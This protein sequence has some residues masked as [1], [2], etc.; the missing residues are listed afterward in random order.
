MKCASYGHFQWLT[1]WTASNWMAKLGMLAW[2]S[3]RLLVVS[4]EHYLLA[5]NV[6]FI[7]VNLLSLHGFRGPRSILVGKIPMQFTFGQRE[8]MMINL[9]T[10]RIIINKIKMMALFNYLSLEKCL[11]NK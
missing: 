3:P 6:I 11:M 8:D 10:T 4:L 9:S 5:R 2:L 1:R 7:F